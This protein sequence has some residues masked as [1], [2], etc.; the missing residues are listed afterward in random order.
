M[1]IFASNYRTNQ[2]QFLFLMA[3]IIT[4]FIGIFGIHYVCA[5]YSKCIHTNCIRRLIHLNT[6]QSFKSTRRSFTL[7]WKLCLQIEKFH[8]NNRYGFSYGKFGII[9][10]VS[11]VRFLFIYCKLIMM[12]IKNLKN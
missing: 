7:H 3:C 9:S 11:F 1:R 6:V 5:Q 10:L 4:E 8:T 2:S 12:I